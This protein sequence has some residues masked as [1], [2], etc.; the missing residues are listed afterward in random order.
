MGWKKLDNSSKYL[1]FPKQHCLS[2]LLWS[3]LTTKILAGM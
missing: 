1:L 2:N 3:F